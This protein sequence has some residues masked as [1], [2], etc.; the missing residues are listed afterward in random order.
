MKNLL[1]PV[2]TV[3]IGLLPAAAW[4]EPAPGAGQSG[5]V[6]LLF[7][8]GF[9]LI[10]YFLMWRPQSKRA[11]EHK[12]LIGGLSKGDEV[13]TNGGIA[14]RIVRVKDDFIVIE[15]SDNVEIKV[16]KVAVA[17]ALPKGTLKEV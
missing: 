3:L 17:A 10:F 11:K 9:I 16:Q 6:Q 13:I 5:L 12:E 2:L 7:F 4:A 14:G 1:A 15:V 8:G